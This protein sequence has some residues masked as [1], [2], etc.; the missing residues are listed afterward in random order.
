[1]F[2][3]TGIPQGG[4]RQAGGEVKR[5]KRGRL[6][7]SPNTLRPQRDRQIH[8]ARNAGVYSPSTNTLRPQRGRLFPLAIYGEGVADRPGVRSDPAPKQF[9]KVKRIFKCGSPAKTPKYS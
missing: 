7:P 5:T 3:K 8:D 4:G 1:M 2:T 6:S 9:T